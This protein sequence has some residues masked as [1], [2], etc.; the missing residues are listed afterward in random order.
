VLTQRRTIAI[1]AGVVVTAVL[2]LGA[3]LSQPDPP[4]DAGEPATTS[5]LATPAATGRLVRGTVIGDSYTAGTP[6]G[7]LGAKGWVPV[8][9]GRLGAKGLPVALRVSAHPASG[10]LTRGFDGTTFLDAVRRDVSARD[11]VVVLYGSPNDFGQDLELLRK[12]ATRAI[13]AAQ[14]RA[15]EARVVVVGIAYADPRRG[16]ATGQMQRELEQA[17]DDAGATF[18]DPLDDEWFGGTRRDLIDTLLSHPT[19]EGHAHVADEMLDVLAPLVKKVRTTTAPGIAET[20]RDTKAQDAERGRRLVFRFGDA[21]VGRTFEGRCAKGVTG[22]L[23]VSTDGGRVFGR[24]GTPIGQVLGVDTSDPD[25]LTVVG[26]DIDCAGPFRFTRG[27]EAGE[28]VVS[29]ASGWFLD[30]SR[31]KLHAPS[32]TVKPGCKDVISLSPLTDD[33]ARVGCADGTLRGTL[34][35]GDTWRTL[36]ELEGLRAVSYDSPSV[37]VALAA[38]E[39]C[40]ARVF[41]TSDGGRSWSAR[42]CLDGTTA[43]AVWLDEEGALALVNNVLAL[44]DDRGLTWSVR[45]NGT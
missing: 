13:R 16:E 35:G 33:A 4:P 18:V 44:S 34:D 15:P 41:T 31:A 45:F 36:G 38:F 24:V 21:L 22:Q 25:A 28:W 7:G 32:G 27:L 5:S 3:V 29:P 26:L 1:V 14:K 40:A 8:L 30:P 6:A 39:G 42:R 10:Y 17:A 20:P 12:A 9:Q 43:E 23:E 11:D 37:A 19:D 2:C